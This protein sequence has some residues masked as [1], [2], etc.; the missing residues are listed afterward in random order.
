M[1][2]YQET[3]SEAL[4]SSDEAL[5]VYSAQP[6]I[7]ELL[8]MGED[9]NQYVVVSEGLGFSGS[10]LLS[11]LAEIAEA[12]GLSDTV[13]P[14]VYIQG[15]AVE[16]LG[17]G[18]GYA[19]HTLIGVKV[20]QGMSLSETA[21]AVS[22]MQAFAEDGIGLAVIQVGEETFIGVV[23][24]LG[25]AAVTEYSLPGFDSVGRFD[26]QLIFSDAD[27]L[28]LMDSGADEGVDI[29]SDIVS[30]AYVS[31]YKMRTTRGYFTL[32]NDGAMVVSLLH[33]APDG[34]VLE[35]LQELPMS[36]DELTVQRVKFGRGM[37]SNQ[38]YFRLR[39][40]GGSDFE[41]SSV[42]IESEKKSRKQ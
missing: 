2:T 38:Y 40:K 37:S 30:K 17:L 25:N 39:N 1:A 35:A 4:G 9:F 20:A 7:S 41:I 29:Q 28:Y 33:R 26:G 32:V 10:V 5:H 8:G 14:M 23:M 31:P 42:E 21:Q 6:S 27:G 11:L 18:E 22:Q 15:I 16:S 13:E 19:V 24:N 3:V 12:M 36:S 34:G